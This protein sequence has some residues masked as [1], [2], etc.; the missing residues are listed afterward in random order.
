MI[1]MKELEA[2]LCVRSS[3][4]LLPLEHPKSGIWNGIE[5][6]GYWNP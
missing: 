3:F 2:A 5:I 4:S 1:C 6:G